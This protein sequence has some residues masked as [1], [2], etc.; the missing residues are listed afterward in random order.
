MQALDHLFAKSRSDTHD[1]SYNANILL[2]HI[3]R[4]HFREIVDA[5]ERHCGQCLELHALEED[6]AD[7]QSLHPERPARRPGE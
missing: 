3:M 6:I 2:G 4:R 7:I 1:T 5:L